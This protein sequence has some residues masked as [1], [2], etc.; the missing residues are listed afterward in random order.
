MK[1]ESIEKAIGILVNAVPYSEQI[2]YNNIHNEAIYFEWRCVDFKLDL[3]TGR[4]DEHINGCLHGT[5]L[6]IAF[7][8]LVRR[9][10]IAAI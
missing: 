7:T 10:I 4:V 9:Q 6:A 1:I 3:Q 2:N 5:N 8:E